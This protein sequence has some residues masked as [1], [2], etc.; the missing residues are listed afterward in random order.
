MS[1]DERDEYIKSSHD[2][3]MKLE[4]MVLAHDKSLYGNGQPGAVDR[5]TVIETTQKEC[6]KRTAV[7]PSVRSN[8][9]ALAALIVCAIGIIVQAMG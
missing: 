4:P 8:W 5:I 3:L 1:N 2:I 7:A 9:I 6:Q